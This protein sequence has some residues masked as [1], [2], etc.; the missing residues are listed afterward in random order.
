MGNNAIN[1]APTIIAKESRSWQERDVQQSKNSTKPAKKDKAEKAQTPDHR[2]FLK[3]INI[4]HKKAPKIKMIERVFCIRT[5]VRS[6]PQLTN[7]LRFSS[8]Y[9]LGTDKT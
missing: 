8:V 5:S 7:K 9:S 1:P 3:T 6:E 2:V 4:K